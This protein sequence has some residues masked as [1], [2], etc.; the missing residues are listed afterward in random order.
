ALAC[1]QAGADLGDATL[2][3]A[4]VAVELATLV[5][6]PGVDDQRVGG[7]VGGGHSGA[8]VGAGG[9]GSWPP[10]CRGWQRRMRRR[11]SQLPLRAPNRPRAVIAYSEQ[12][13]TN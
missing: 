12:V 5:H 11:A 2:A 9:T 7:R 6:Q 4:Q 3:D 1:A 10:G 13:G 8:P